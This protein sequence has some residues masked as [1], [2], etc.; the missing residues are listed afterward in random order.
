MRRH[1]IVTIPWFGQTILTLGL[2][3]ARQC[4]PPGPVDVYAGE[5]EAFD[6]VAREMG[7]NITRRSGSLTDPNAYAWST[8]E[9]LNILRTAQKSCIVLAYPRIV[10][11]LD[12]TE[13]SVAEDIYCAEIDGM[14]FRGLTCLFR[15]G[16]QI[17]VP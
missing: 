13:P 7:L 2:A 11:C 6:R 15:G 4:L 5:G 14:N 16:N 12:G 17:G 10:D 1:Y 9:I 3:T 8:G